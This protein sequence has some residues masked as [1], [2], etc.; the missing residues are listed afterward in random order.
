MKHSENIDTWSDVIILILGIVLFSI[1]MLWVGQAVGD[2]LEA[3]CSDNDHYNK[4]V[5]LIDINTNKKITYH[6]VAVGSTNNST[7]TYTITTKNGQEIN[8]PKSR[9]IIKTDKTLNNKQLRRY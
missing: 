3:S 5:E 7:S 4:N 1:A 2:K 6:N 9:Y 8:Y